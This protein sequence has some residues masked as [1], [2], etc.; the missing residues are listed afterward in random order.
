MAAKVKKGDRVVVLAGRDKGKQ[1][2]VLKVLPTEN[3]VVV[4]G[5]MMVKRHQKAGPA[6]SRG[7]DRGEGGAD[8]ASPTSPISTPRT[9]SRRGSASSSSRMAARCASPS[10]PARSSIAE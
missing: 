4:Q 2:E 10:A 8:R 9:A 1:G 6:Q 5:V 7:R 3:R